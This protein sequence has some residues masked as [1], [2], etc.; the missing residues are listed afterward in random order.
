MK[1]SHISGEDL[2]KVLTTGRGPVVEELCK[3]LI[4]CAC[5]RGRTPGALRDQGAYVT[6]G[7]PAHKR[8]IAI[9]RPDAGVNESRSKAREEFLVG[10][11]SLRFFRNSGDARPNL[12]SR[13]E[14]IAEMLNM[15]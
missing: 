7:F 1:K 10:A 9:S 12:A 4:R 14:F 8:E 3:Y 2:L 6:Y 11:V 15:K 5:A 13:S